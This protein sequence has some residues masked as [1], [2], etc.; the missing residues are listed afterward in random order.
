MATQIQHRRGTTVG[1]ASFTGAAGEITVDTDK[2]ILIVHDGATAAG[3]PVVSTTATQ[4]MTNKT[5]TSPVLNTG[6]SGSAF[7]DED[8]MSSNSATKLASQQSIK[9]Y[10]DTG[11]AAK[12]ATTS[13]QSLGSAANAMTISGNTITLA[14]GDST[15]DVVTVPDNNTTYSPG[16][17]LDI[18]GTTFSV[19]SDL[20]SD[21]FQIGRDTND[22]YIVNTTTHD[23]YL[24]GA[25]DM[26]LANNGDLDVDG[27]VTAYSVTTT[28]DEKLKLGI[29]NV[30]NALEKVKQLNGI[31]FT[32]KKDGTKGAGVTAQD[33][34]KVLPQA[35]KLNKNLKTQEEF[36]SVNYDA[37]HALLI[38]SIK[39]LSAEIEL[40][41]KGA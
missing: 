28:S 20:R 29:R 37:L 24:D 35:V 7:L 4:T 15:T 14:R 9:A 27:D 10:V 6:V 30:D 39:E 5:L 38:E 12:T 13:N 36:K 22:Y 18:S 16:A 23:W 19:E 3:F 8:T 25:L 11:L 41:K 31:E 32:W 21:V 17:G 1:H 34:E 33:V 26:R 2:D 40:L